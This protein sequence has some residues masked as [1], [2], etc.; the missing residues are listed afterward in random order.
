MVKTTEVSL[1]SVV[2]I[3][4]RARLPCARD[5]SVE[6]T[7]SHP[8]LLI[9]R[10]IIHPSGDSLLVFIGSAY[11][12]WLSRYSDLV[13]LSACSCLWDDRVFWCWCWVFDVRRLVCWLLRDIVLLGGAD[14][15]WVDSLCAC[16]ALFSDVLSPWI[17][18]S[19]CVVPHLQI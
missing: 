4:W 16:F 12:F 13:N 14:L 19:K 10:P 8:P 3:T 1:V 18:A 9:S 6:W 11:V 7:S 17:T 5:L 2:P 15:C